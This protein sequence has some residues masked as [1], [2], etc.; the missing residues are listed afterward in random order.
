[1]HS[2]GLNLGR[3]SALN[4]NKRWNSRGWMKEK[5]FVISRC[6][7]TLYNFRSGLFEVS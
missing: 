3:T 7:W 5:V 2:D 4:T 6:A 1:M